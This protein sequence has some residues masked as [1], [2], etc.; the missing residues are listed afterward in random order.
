M[1]G[2]PFEAESRVGDEEV[3]ELEEVEELIAEDPGDSF[4]FQEKQKSELDDENEFETTKGMDKEVSGLISMGS[5]SSGPGSKTETPWPDTAVYEESTHGFQTPHV[6]HDEFNSAFKSIDGTLSPSLD[7]KYYKGKKR[8]RFGVDWKPDSFPAWSESQPPLSIE[9]IAEIFHSM[10]KIFGFQYDSMKNMFEY[11]MM[12]LDSRASRMGAQMALVTLHADYIGGEHANYRRWFFASKLVHEED[13]LP[14]DKYMEKPSNEKPPKRESIPMS[15]LGME[16]LEFNWMAKMNKMPPEERVSQ[17]VLYLLC[18]G[19]AN[20]VRF[21]PECLAFIFKCAYDYYAAQRIPLIDGGG[22]YDGHFLDTVITPLY[23]FCRDQLYQK[24]DN[25]YVH[26]EHDHK[27]TIGYDDMNQLFWH[28]EGI[29]RLVT[30]SGTRLL[31]LRPE[32]RYPQLKN[33]VWDK[34]FYKTYRESRSWLHMA[35]NFNRIWIIHICVFWFYTSFNVPYLYTVDYQYTKN[36]EPPPQIRWSIIAAGGGIA[37]LINLI[38]TFAELTF[39]PR[40]WPGA[41]GVVVRIL[42][43]LFNLSLVVGP[44]AYIF[45]SFPWDEKDELAT[46]IAIIQLTLSIITV[47]VYTVVPLGSVL[48]LK[49]PHS[50]DRLAETYFTGA[51]HKLKDNDRLISYG[52][53]LCIFVAKFVESYF[54]L[55]LSL[56]DPVRELSVMEH[57][58]C[59]GDVYLGSWLCNHQASV[60]LGMM[61]VTDLVLFFLDTYLWYII[62]NTLFSVARSFYLG[63][64]IWTPWRNIYSRLPKRIFSKVLFTRHLTKKYRSKHLISQIWNAVIVSMYR[65]HLLPLEQVQRLVYHQERSPEGGEKILFEPAFFV[66]QEDQSFKTSL[67]ESQCEAERRISFFAQSLSTP[68]PEPLPVENMPAFTV[69]VPHY[70]ERIILSLREIIREEDDNTK[71]TLL[72]YLKKLHPLEWDCFVKDTMGLANDGGLPKDFSDEDN[73]TPTEKVTQ[74]PYYCIG[75]KSSSPEYVLR[76]RLWASLRTQTLYRTISGFM[77]YPRAIKLLYSVETLEHIPDKPKGPKLERELVNMARRKFRLIAAIQ[78]MSKFT[79]SEIQDKEMMLRAYPEINIAYL[80]EDIP[81]QPGAEPAYYSALVDGECEIMENGQRKPRYRIRLSGN[82]ILGDGKSDNQ[83]HALIFCRGEYIQ[84]VDANQDNYLEECLKIRSV[85]AEFEDMGP[86]PHPYAYV[87]QKDGPEKSAPVAILGAR[88][89]VFS[90]NIGVLGDVAAGKEQTFGTLFARTLAKIGGKLHYGHPDFLNSIFM[91]TRGGVSKAQKGLHLNE[92]IYAGMNALLRGGRIKHCEFNQCG[93]GRDLGFGSILNFTTKIGAGMGEQMLSREYFYLGTKLPLD[94]F[95][96]FYYAHPG[97]HINNMFIVVSLELFLLVSLNLAAL[98]RGAVICQY[99]KDAPTTDAHHPIGCQNMIPVFKWIQRC[100]LSIFVVFFISFLPLFVQELTERG[101]WRSITRLGKHFGSLSPLFEVFVCQIYAQS[102]VHDLS[103]GGAKYISTGRGFAT[104]RI[105]FTLLY[106][107]FAGTSLY[108]GVRLLLILIF[109]SL[110]MWSVSLLWFWMTTVALCLAPVLYNPHQ[111]SV[112]DFFLDYRQFMRWLS[113]G[114]IKWHHNSWIGYTRSTRTQI[115]GYK[116]KTFGEISE[117]VSK[118]IK[119]PSFFNKFFSQVFG[120]LVL[121]LAVVIPYLYVNSQVNLKNGDPTNPLLRLAVV[122]FGPI[123]VN[124]IFLL[125]SFVISCS[126][127]CLVSR[128][129]QRIPAL[130][131]SILHF[132]SVINHVAFF[133]LLWLLESW[134]LPN[135]LIGLVASLLVQSFFFK[136]LLVFFMTREMKNDNSNRVWWS[137]RWSSIGLGWRMA[138]Q[139]G[140]ELLCKVVEMSLFAMDFILGHFILFVQTPILFIPYVD[141][142]HTLVLFWL[143]PGRHVRSPIFP[144]RLRKRRKRLFRKYSLLY[145]MVLFL[146]LGALLGPPS[147]PQNIRMEL[148]ELVDSFYP[149]IVQPPIPVIKQE[150]NKEQT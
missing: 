23:K 96:S 57:P 60:V 90:E 63:A 4:D 6:N 13:H 111:F 146:F 30:E 120:T 86:R 33:V 43:Y 109:V 47:L 7:E 107:R 89:Y 131:A 44:T 50:K 147:V 137:G 106:S 130:L 19:E 41:E 82:P 10:R 55:T 149:G 9:Q 61:L 94:R 68:I 67:F 104:T 35:V 103:L 139:P 102:L 142:W 48:R 5:Y 133:E 29:E 16:S 77:N 126:I 17:T 124:L 112:V 138:S 38:G 64:S 46:I 37:P 122:S 39:V 14:M 32:D 69:L 129:W 36:N 95:L 27:D 143:N 91:T 11:F 115:T 34:V 58:N 18:W 59:V 62:F 101:F 119:R 81:D 20:Q 93:K 125:V 117:T 141:K 140:R 66:S 31:G 92:D 21:M 116:V 42:G 83:N 123:L 76:T 2:N 121:M 72:E 128:K 136:C 80:E 28:R 150:A 22:V 15:P 114:N 12:L 54:F 49:S 134:N 75:F 71:V 88:E 3:D 70:G 85:L 78:R 53:W 87:N 24:L 45:I 113:R 84:L 148:C 1:E 65:E 100:V 132:F 73:T 51:F 26:K 79:Q 98:A 25:C 145:F 52:L 110:T 99:D 40:K 118:D 8:L 56:R 108:F 127:C 144:N 135:T 97:F 74:L 105:S